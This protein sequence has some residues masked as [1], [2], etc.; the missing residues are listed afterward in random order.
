ML[1]KS[2]YY[3][4]TDDQMFRVVAECNTMEEALEVC[5]LGPCVARFVCV[6]MIAESNTMEEL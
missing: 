5:R 2:P 3:G 6:C 1:Y 4:D